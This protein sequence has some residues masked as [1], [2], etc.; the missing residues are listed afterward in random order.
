[1]KNTFERSGK[2]FVAVGTAAA[3]LLS[4]CEA[5][6]KSPEETSSVSVAERVNSDTSGEAQRV[7]IEHAPPSA[8][9]AR[10]CG[11]TAVR[12]VGAWL[13]KA[14]FSGDPPGELSTGK[15]GSQILF[16]ETSIGYTYEIEVNVDEAANLAVRGEMG[17]QSTATRADAALAYS[18]FKDATFNPDVPIA[19]WNL[20]NGTGGTTDSEATICEA[21]QDL[22]D[23]IAADQER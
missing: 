12:A 11:Y 7:L 13:Y 22:V 20:S 4:G 5:E 9:P 3:L 1:M 19:V 15:Y 17:L 23:A 8:N 14:D 21:T 18:D 2:P 6:S 16:K 10:W